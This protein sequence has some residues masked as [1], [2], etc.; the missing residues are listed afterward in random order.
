MRKHEIELGGDY[1]A[2]VSGR[3]TT[4]RIYAVHHLGGW[5]A[6]NLAT[7]RDI[8]IRTAARLRKREPVPMMETE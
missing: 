6:T 2:K 7:G 3:L 8:R 4:V 5:W 1:T